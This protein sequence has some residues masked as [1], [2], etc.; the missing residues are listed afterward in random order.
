MKAAPNE[1]SIHG[2]LLNYT[3]AAD[4][5]GGEVEIE[6]IRQDGKDP[7]S[8]FIRPAVGSRVRAF[9]PPESPAP[10]LPVGQRVNATLTFSGG[11]FGSRIVVRSLRPE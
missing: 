5:Y 11:P 7:S 9:C 1:T 2:T 4:G 8:D 6:V 10:N 3:P